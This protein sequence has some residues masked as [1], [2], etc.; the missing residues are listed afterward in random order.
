MDR[1]PQRRVAVIGSG[2]AG[3]TAAYLLRQ[4]GAEVWLIEKVCFVMDFTDGRPIDLGSILNLLI[5]P[6]EI[7]L[8]E[9]R[10]HSHH[11]TGRADG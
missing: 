10:R 11:Q 9:E 1:I 8:S 3:L 6:F 4:E 7:M 5:Y 2:L